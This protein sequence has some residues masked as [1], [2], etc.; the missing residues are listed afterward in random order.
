MHV[1][2]NIILRCLISVG[3]TCLINQFV[4]KTVP[5]RYKNT[6]GADLLSKEVLVDDTRVK[7]QVE[8]GIVFA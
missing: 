8:A 7:L 2:N 5:M 4:N 6:I 1:E 3:K